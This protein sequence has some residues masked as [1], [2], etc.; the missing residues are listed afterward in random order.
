MRDAQS[1]LAA[2]A[3]QVRVCEK[4]VITPSARDFLRQNK[5]ELVIG[6]AC[7]VLALSGSKPRRR[8]A[9]ARRPIS[10]AGSGSGAE[11]AACRIR[12]AAVLHARGRG[13]QEGD[14]RGRQEAVEPQYVDGNGGN[15]SY[16]IGPNEVLCTPT[17]V[18]KF[19]LTPDD[20]CLVDLDGKQIA[21]K[22]AA[23]QRDLPASGDL[24]GCA[25]GEGLR[26]LPSAACHRLC[27]HRA[28][29]AQPGH[30]GVRGLRRQGRDLALRDAGH[31]RR[32]R[33]PCC[34]T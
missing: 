24:Q 25:G 22:Q 21:G 17:L 2:G 27:H 1:A 18:S 20:L 12:C 30:S 13:H 6:R 16:R 33:R 3:T 15:I 26:P 8:A 34:P 4:C 10:C 19:D 28:R 31:G 9:A 14:M 5:I 23:H 29:S 7:S 32:S 11:C